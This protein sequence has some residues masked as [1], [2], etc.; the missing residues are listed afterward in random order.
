MDLLVEELDGK[1]YFERGKH[2]VQLDNLFISVK[3]LTQLYK[4]E[5]GA[6]GMVRTTKI[7]CEVVEEWDAEYM[8][9][10]LDTKKTPPK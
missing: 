4:E 3:L 5:I 8:E 9:L 1:R 6:V 10:A 2:I 7:R